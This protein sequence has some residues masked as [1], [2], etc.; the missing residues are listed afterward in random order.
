VRTLLD[1]QK[2][3]APPAVRLG[4]ARSVLELGVKLRAAAELEE[5]LTALEEQVA[6]NAGGR[7]L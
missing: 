7:H 3:A 6:A 2:P 5:R 1:L 4:A